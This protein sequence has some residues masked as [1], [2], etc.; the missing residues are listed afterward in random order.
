M[1]CCSSKEKSEFLENEKELYYR[2]LG[3]FMISYS[4]CQDSPSR[5]DESTFIA[6]FDKSYMQPGDVMYI[7]NSKWLSGWHAY[8]HGTGDRSKV[9]QIDNNNLYSFAG[10]VSLR[11]GLVVNHDYKPVCREVWE[12]YFQHYGGTPVIYFHVPS[13]FSEEEYKSGEWLHG[14]NLSELCDVIY[15]LPDRKKAPY[16]LASSRTK[17]H[18]LGD[19]DEDSVALSVIKT[20]EDLIAA[21]RLSRNVGLN[22]IQEGEA[23]TKKITTANVELIAM[24]MVQDQ[25]RHKFNEA[26]GM[27]EDINKHNSMECEGEGD[28]AAVEVLVAQQLRLRE[29]GAALRLQSAIRTRRAKRRVAALRAERKRLL[30]EGDHIMCLNFVCQYI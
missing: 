29:E 4:A 7:I 3:G 21:S 15:P 17:T 14:V 16:Q 20:D 5:E 23:L 2:N 24:G 27:D 6:D 10:R 26:S 25:A 9:G 12:Y 22:N 8:I 28:A 13:G 19:E 18:R 30:E 11:K 1:G